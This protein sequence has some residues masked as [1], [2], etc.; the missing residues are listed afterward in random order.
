[1]IKLGGTI[2]VTNGS[3][4]VV[5][6]DT[7]FV[8]SV[9]AGDSISIDRSIFYRVVTV[10][11]DTQLMID[12]TY[13]EATASNLVA[14]LLPVSPLR[15]NTAG[16]SAQ[17]TDFLQRYRDVLVNSGADRR[18]TLNKAA[19]TDYSEIVHQAAGVNKFKTGL[20][21]DNEWGLYAFI[22]NA[23]SP[24]LKTVTAGVSPSQTVT[25]QYALGL[26]IAVG[27]AALPGYAF[28]GRLDTGMW[29]PAAGT[30]AWSAGGSEVARSTNALY[31]LAVDAN[32]SKAS[33]RLDVNKAAAGQSAL[34]RSYTNNVQRWQI[35]FGDATAE[36]GGNA[37][38]DFY[39]R[40]Y[41][42][43]GVAIGDAL[44]VTRSSMLAKFGGTTDSTSPSSGGAQF[45]G[46]VG[47]AGDL[48]WGGAQ[49]APF[50]FTPLSETGTFTTVSGSGRYKLFGKKIVITFQIVCT[51]V[52]TANGYVRI[53]VPVD[54]R[55]G[56]TGVGAIVNVSTNKGGT[57]HAGY[58]SVSHIDCRLYDG[59]FPITSGQVIWGS[60]E[61]ETN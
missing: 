29:S 11:N 20:V 50:S 22:N 2:G 43:A 21:A 23:W 40:A 14:W 30:I 37:G 46:G 61:Y 16:V 51:N 36:S 17:V 52:G 27:T 10:V 58:L 31:T 4:T 32:M 35:D 54:V 56:T 1:M 28:V 5:G 24:A 34:L 59:S 38:S 44:R 47:I 45:A 42:D 6:T 3:A 12:P 25:L 49:W 60:V 41:N 57:A 9:V 18:L 8:S 19:A 39:V 15:Q 7:S 13:A 33:P 55:G 48:N 53:P 26:S